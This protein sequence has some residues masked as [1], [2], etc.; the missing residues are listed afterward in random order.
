MKKISV[1]KLVALLPS[2]FF[3]SLVFS[4]ARP[5]TYNIYMDY[6]AITDTFE[7]IRTD[8]T[9]S[10]NFSGAAPYHVEHKKDGVIGLIAPEAGGGNQQVGIRRRYSTFDITFIH[11][12]NQGLYFT[13]PS[14]IKY[15]RMWFSVLSGYYFQDNSHN[16]LCSSAG[17]FD[18]FYV[19]NNSNLNC[20][21]RTN[22]MSTK[23]LSEF[24]T[25]A[26]GVMEYDFDLDNSIRRNLKNPNFKPGIYRASYTYSGDSV[27]SRVNGRF[28]E[29][30][31]FNI[32]IN[33]IKQLSE[34]TFPLGKSAEFKTVKH[35]GRIYGNVELPFSM[36]GV[37][38]M[39][40]KLN[41]TFQ[42]SNHVDGV[43]NMSH[44]TANSRIPYSVTLINAGIGSAITYSKNNETKS[45]TA[46]ANDDF[47]GLI[48]FDFDAEENITTGRYTDTL[49]IISSVEL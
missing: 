4:D 47:S 6:N 11:K 31:T 29:K 16:G 44:Q 14:G 30:Y 18:E 27:H 23:D 43:F 37:F 49:T 25:I 41:F 8:G 28:T 34:F 7:N 17:R 20:V 15:S 19:T 5:V 10:V 40:Q 46:V 45:V 38:A 39:G 1:I 33:K 9:L 12:D 32:E 3:N 13:S 24:P 35:G 36:S 2:L 42:S 22:E 48:K 21:A 26:D